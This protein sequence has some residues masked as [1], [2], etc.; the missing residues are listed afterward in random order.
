MGGPLLAQAGA[1]QHF[2][3]LEEAVLDTLD[4]VVGERAVGRAIADGDG[5]RLLALWEPLSTVVV[6]DVGF[7]T[8]R[9][10]AV[11]ADDAKDV[12]GRGVRVDEKREVDI[13]GEA[14]TS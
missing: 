4:I 2:Q 1:H 12:T 11:A 10:R 9:L 7:D 13:D 5:E 6:E 14:V 8:D 3:A